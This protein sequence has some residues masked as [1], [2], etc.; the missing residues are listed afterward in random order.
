M[1]TLAQYSFGRITV[2]GQLHMRDVIVVPNRV[3]GNWWRR[4]GHSLQ[5]EDLEVVLDELPQRLIVGCGAD[6]GLRP[7]PAALAKLSQRGVK[8]EVL[9]TEDAVRRYGELDEGDT[10]VALHL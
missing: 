9:R 4:E 1:A 8:V 6:G 2:D 5:I 3:I 7:D 10:A